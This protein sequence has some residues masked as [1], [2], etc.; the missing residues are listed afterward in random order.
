MGMGAV[1][2]YRLARVHVNRRGA[3]LIPGAL[4]IAATV[5]LSWGAWESAHDPKWPYLGH[6]WWRAGL[7][8]DSNRTLLAVA[9]VWLLALVCYWWPRKLMPAV[10]GLTTVVAMVAVGGV[11]ATSSLLPCRGGQ[12]TTAVAAWV[13]GLY[14]GN[15][16]QVYGAGACPGQPPLALQL[17]QI[18]CLGATLLGALAAAAVLWQQPLDRFRSRFVRDAT[19]LTGLDALTMP[20][21]RQLADT[22]RPAS[23]VVIEPDASH[24]LLDEARATGAHV[25][26]G[27]PTSARILL[28]IFAGWRGCALSYLYAL[29]DDVAENER[30]LAAARGVLSRYQPDPERQPHLVMRIDDPR[31]ADHWR[32]WHTGASSRYFEDALSPQ[33]STACALVSQVLRTGA[34][35][36]LLCGDST[37]ALA[38]LLELGRRAWEQQQLIAAAAGRPPHPDAA[39]PPADRPAPLPVERVLLLDRRSPDLRREYLATS[40]PALARQLPAVTARPEP[41]RDRLLALL[42]D[43]APA[44]AAETAVVI[45]DALSEDSAHE[46]GRVAR[47]HPGVPVFVPVSG[48]ADANEPIFGLLRPFP[49]T[50]LVDGD[51]PEDTWTR[52]ARHWHECFRLQHP[53]VPG[54]PRT[55]TGR[56]WNELDEFIQQDNILQLRSIM[57]AVV[58]H[59]RRWVPGR[60]VTP[61][62]FIELNE[63]ALEEIAQAE[64]TRWYRRRLAAGW[65]PGG[66]ARTR[67]AGRPGHARV[68]RRVV[69]WTELPA[70]ERARNIEH[71]RS[72]LAQL[73][74]VGFMPVVPAGGPPGAAEFRRI[75]TVQAKRLGARQTWTRRSGDE[76][77]G[78]AGDWRVR[79]DHGDERTVRDAEFRA[80]H[81]SLGGEKWLR[82]GTFSAWQVS[83]TQILRTI[84]GRAVA[85]AG[86]WVV[87]GHG[88][89]RWPVTDEQFRRTYRAVNG[90]PGPDRIAN[91]QSAP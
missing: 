89:E 30:V 85:R 84:E 64:H 36:L 10:V 37:L 71:L 47:L 22:G 61:G 88:G 6:A 78:D 12:T 70:G 45:A 33:E 44:D 15:P 4:G 25:M 41:W 74:D 72:Q 56:P 13:L 26:V 73:E 91:G 86:D 7:R 20:L 77:C 52:V 67:H 32:S 14:V 50:L 53:A 62:S 23:I 24:P 51:V 87:E 76:L 60:S 11:L 80:S 19:V 27:D 83:E 48:E 75:G 55:L 63:T 43:L 1:M 54:E 82:T 58:S 46:A 28:P 29:R 9:A 81:E 40:S 90:R 34:R 57:T 8:P 39:G 31:H 16:P 65:S 68:N 79:D 5:Y 38:T 35:A 3:W 49:R 2:N 59:G 69:P 66:A 18:V 17:G 21:L 42:D